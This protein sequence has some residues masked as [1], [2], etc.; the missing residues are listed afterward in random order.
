VRIRRVSH[1]SPR[2]SQPVPPI[3]LRLRWPASSVQ[4]S[5]WTC[6]TLAHRLRQFGP[7]SARRRVSRQ[8]KT[9]GP[10]LKPGPVTKSSQ[11]I[12]GGDARSLWTLGLLPK[13]GLFRNV[14]IT[15]SLR[16]LLQLQI[17][18]LITD[19]VTGRVGLPAN[20]VTDIAGEFELRTPAQYFSSRPV[21]TTK[22]NST[23]T[24]SRSGHCQIAHPHARNR[25]RPP[26]HYISGR[27]DFPELR[28]QLR[29]ALATLLLADGAKTTW[30]RVGS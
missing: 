29:V 16:R 2:L 4:A 28:F 11:A 19:F 23:G 6:A 5:F 30:L 8:V 25:I 17:G 15:D 1:D 24:R 18:A 21:L 27:P 13:P 9:G 7:N 20:R 22:S 14:L 10:V 26:L 3:Q 12:V